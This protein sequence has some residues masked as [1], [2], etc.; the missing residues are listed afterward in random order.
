LLEKAII[1]E[2][3]FEKVRKNKHKYKN[4][5]EL[6]DASFLALAINKL[7]NREF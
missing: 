7:D 5:L 6:R 4:L 3:D 2:G 1:E